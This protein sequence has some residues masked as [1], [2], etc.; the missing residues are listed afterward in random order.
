MPP[1]VY[2]ALSEPMVHH[3]TPEFNKIL[4]K[5]HEQLKTVFKTQQPV[6]MHTSTGS[7]AMESAIVN[8]LS[9]ND[10]VLVVVAGK[11]GERWRDMCQAYKIKKVHTLEIPWGESVNIELFEKKL[12]SLPNLKAV[13][14]QYC[15]TST[16]A[17]MPIREMSQVLRKFP[18]ILFMVDAITAIGA[19][20]LEMDLWNLDVVCAGSQKAFMMPTGLSFVS[21]SEK[22]WEANK[23]SDLPKF[24]FDLKKEREVQTKAQT[25][26]SSA[27]THVK[28]LAAYFEYFKK[29]GGL[30][31]SIS[32]C[33]KLSSAT[34]KSLAELGLEIF[35]KIPSPSLTTVRVPSSIRA[36]DLR[37]TLEDK[38]GVVVM[39]GQDQL[40]DSIL[41]I[42]HLGYITNESLVSGINSLAKSLMD[43]GYPLKSSQIE[44]MNAILNSELS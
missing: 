38:Y 30:V 6:L 20:E 16:G 28:A 2:R 36:R 23:K 5:C 1:E 44:N 8:T 29:N 15:E 42:G 37:Q 17:L 14:S 27:V 13:L 18:E 19:I 3:R 25:Y 34:Q 40:T 9:Q 41:R 21:M 7:G 26:Y 32:R 22:A 24:Y 39:C 4:E 43:L 11:F 31:G 35:P 12:S 10:E 33:K